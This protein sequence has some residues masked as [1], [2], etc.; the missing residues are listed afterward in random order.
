M[1]GAYYTDD[2]P[3][4][5]GEVVKVPDGE[6]GQYGRCRL[7]Y[8]NGNPDAGHFEVEMPGGAVRLVPWADT[9]KP[10]PV[11]SGLDIPSR[12]TPYTPKYGKRRV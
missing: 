6:G 5:I 11:P 7:G 8:F 2:M 4:L 12:L 10:W 9:H 3:P 1:S